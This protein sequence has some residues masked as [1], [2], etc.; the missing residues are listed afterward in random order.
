M[1]WPAFSAPQWSF[2]KNQA[3][4]NINKVENP[5]IFSSDQDPALCAA[6]A[7]SI[8]SIDLGQMIS[9]QCRDFF[10]LDPPKELAQAGL[11]VLNPPYGRRLGTDQEGRQRLGA[12]ATKLT[13][14]F[15]G[16]RMALLVPQQRWLKL[17]P[18]PVETRPLQ[19]G[20][21]R[22]HLALGTI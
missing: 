1:G 15:K 2:L 16:W 11:V 18:F 7:Q 19:H 10:D 13:T 14:D 8:E 9:L 5:I 4:E 20:G 3:S 12:I 6:L 21:L 17:L 22:L